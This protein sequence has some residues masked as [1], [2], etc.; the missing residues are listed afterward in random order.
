MNDSGSLHWR[1]LGP[2]RASPRK[3]KSG[4]DVAA[5]DWN[6]VESGADY[7]RWE[8]HGRSL[9]RTVGE[10][11]GLKVLDIGCGQGWF[12]RQLAS[13]GARVVGLDWSSE[14]VAIAEEHERRDKL[15]IKYLQVD[16]TKIG[17]FWPRGSFDLIASCMAFMDMPRLDRVMAG[18]ARL[19]RRNGRLVFSVSHPVTTAPVSRW[20]RKQVGHHGPRLIDGYFDVGP[21]DVLWKLRGTGRIMDVPQWHRTFAGW[22]ELLR[23]SNLVVTRIWE[24]R[25]TALQVRGNPGFEGVSRIPF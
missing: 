22:F 10:V 24:P 8:V 13:K 23:K 21:V 14:M 15:G 2:S 17:K 20:L 11:R 4:W 5:R 19:L 9:V 18:I 12:S 6:Y 1:K 25:P 16:A 3:A 7:H